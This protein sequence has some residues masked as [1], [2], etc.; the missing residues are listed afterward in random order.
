MANA[1]PDLLYSVPSPW[2]E[3]LSMEPIVLSQCE[4]SLTTIVL[5]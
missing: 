5:P 2:S 3:T 1:V 4:G